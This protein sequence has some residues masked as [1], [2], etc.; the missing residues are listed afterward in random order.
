MD[1]SI[2]SVIAAYESRIAALERDK[3]AVAEKLAHGIQ[4]RASFDDTLRTALC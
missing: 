1:A 3:L 4:P 2:P